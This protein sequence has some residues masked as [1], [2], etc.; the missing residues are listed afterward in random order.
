MKALGDLPPDY[1]LPLV[2]RDLYG[3][4]VRGDLRRAR[5]APGHGQ[6]QRAPRPHARCGCVCGPTADS[7]GRDR[8]DGLRPLSRGDPALHRRRAGRRAGRRVPEASELL[9]GL[10]GRARRSSRPCAPCCRR[11]GQVDGRRAGR[12]RRPGHVRP[13]RRSPRRR[14]SSA[15]CRRSTARRAARA[16]CPAACAATLLRPRRDRRRHRPRAQ[17]RATGPARAR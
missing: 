6:G 7:T 2:L 11:R 13:S 5:P 16:R 4:R 1:R 15:R 12:L 10:R 8:T 17:V 14:P 3:L 9:S